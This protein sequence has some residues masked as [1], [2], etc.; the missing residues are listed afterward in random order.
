MSSISIRCEEKN[1]ADR[2][3]RLDDNEDW[4][5]FLE[6]AGPDKYMD[7]VKE[8]GSKAMTTAQEMSLDTSTCFTTSIIVVE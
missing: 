5:R 2:S 6:L 7:R 3:Q 4:D 8:W 1:G